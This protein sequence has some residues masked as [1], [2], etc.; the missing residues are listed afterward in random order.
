[1]SR[2]WK[3]SK[4]LATKLMTTKEHVNGHYEVTQTPWTTDYVWMPGEN[5]VDGRI[6]DEVLYPWDAAYVEWVKVER[7]H[8]EE[9]LR[10]EME[11]L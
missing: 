2:E 5:E 7:V 10:M 6:L 1:V 4:T 3:R 9:Q 11:A 8:P